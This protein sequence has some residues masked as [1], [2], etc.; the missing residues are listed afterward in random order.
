MIRQKSRVSKS[1]GSLMSDP[2]VCGKMRRCDGH[3]ADPH[4]IEVGDQLVWDALP[5]NDNDIGNTWWWHS[6]F[7]SECWPI[8]VSR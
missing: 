1:P 5:P 8:E 7:C 6:A 4:W 2:R 3:L